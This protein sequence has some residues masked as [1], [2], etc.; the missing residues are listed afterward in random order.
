MNFV[1]TPMVA[2]NPSRATNIPTVLETRPC[3]PALAKIVA[4]AIPTAYR[5]NGADER[6][7]AQVRWVVYTG[8][9]VIG[10]RVVVLGLSLTLAAAGV[11]L[12]IWLGADVFV[13]GLLLCSAIGVVVL[14]VTRP[15][16]AADIREPDDV[17]QL[18][19]ERRQQLI[20]GTSM[21]LRNMR[22]RYTVRAEHHELS[23]RQCFNAEVNSVH[24]GFVPV[25]IADN[26][27]EKQGFGFVAFVHDGR[28][29]RGPGMPCPGGRERALEHALRCVSPLNDSI[30]SDS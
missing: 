25:V 13:W 2:A 22:Y 1:S 21:H 29:W 24:L 5:D 7:A 14:I 17:S 28:R 8:A 19:K 20:R 3:S 11:A 12:W 30:D 23:D 10:L 4:T 27:T 26:A 15:S 6:S 18:S 9:M 16:A